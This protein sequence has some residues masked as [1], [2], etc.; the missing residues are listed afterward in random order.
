VAPELWRRG[1][2]T[3]DALVVTHADPDHAGGAPFLLRCFRV[4]ELWEG[5][6]PLG[7]VGWRRFEARIDGGRATRVTVA[8]GMGRDW[9]GVRVAVLGPRRPRRPP[10]GVRN[11]DSI[12]LDVEYGEVHL[13]L[14]GDVL[15]REEESLRLPRAF[16]LKVPHHGSRSSSTPA[17][18]ARAAPR[19]AVVSVG[20]RN[21]F[22]HPHPEVLERYGRAGA[23]VLR[24]D[25]DGTLEIATDGRR[26][27]VRAAGEAEERRIR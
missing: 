14:T 24:T 20:A 17:L 27:W 23:L 13:L 5:P 9:D 12:V 6:A 3:L 1:V 22:G 18:L 15:G 10:P 16:V 21:P 25:R 2:R 11:E 8:E 4:R 26:V 7:D 19:L